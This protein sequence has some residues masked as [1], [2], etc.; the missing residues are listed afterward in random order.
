MGGGDLNLKKSWHPALQKNQRR[1]WEEESA[2]LAERKK[3]ELL[4][5]ER[6]EERANEEL[7]LLHEAAGA[8]PTVNRGLEWMYNGSGPDGSGAGVSEE[9]EGYLLGKSRIDT[10][11]KRRNDEAQ[12]ARQ[13]NMEK[14]AGF[15]NAGSARDTATK[16]SSDPMLEMK[17]RE[18]ASYD[19]MMN[20][21]TKRRQLLKQAGVE[22]DEKKTHRHGRR[23]DRQEDRERGS[24]RHR[25][26]NDSDRDARSHRHREDRGRDSRRHRYR[27]DREYDGYRDRQDRDDHYRDDHRDKRRRYHDSD[28]EPDRRPDHHRSRRTPSRSPSRSKE[29]RRDYRAP[30]SYEDR[31]PRDQGARRGYEGNRGDKMDHDGESNNRATKVEDEDQREKDRAAR[32]AAMQSNA[33]QLDQDR[34]K[35][36]EESL[37]RDSA[38]NER[39]EKTR[40]DQGRFMSGVRRQADGMGLGD[41]L[42][43]RGI[44][45][46]GGGD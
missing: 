14:M 15:G 2:A 31:S 4:Q 35:R 32:L 21:P 46:G 41:N 34:Q 27:D 20:D 11:L 8:K 19:A 13:T 29:R 36:L 17:R 6:Q 33:S 30:R 1:V 18:Q 9:A 3:V 22:E 7:R 23:D 5:K 42:S 26:R 16:V 28:S 44:V 40:T 24:H 12:Q 37:A 38:N 43:R 10:L 39:D 45:A 25:H